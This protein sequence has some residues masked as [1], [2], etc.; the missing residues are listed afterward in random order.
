MES[1]AT[2]WRESPDGVEVGGSGFSATLRDYGRYDLFLVGDGQAGG[3]Q[4][5]RDA[6]A[7]TKP[8]GHSTNAGSRQ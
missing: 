5:L 1:D 6:L 3:E 7:D 8:P 4:I 2:W